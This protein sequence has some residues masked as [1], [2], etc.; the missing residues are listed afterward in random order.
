MRHPLVLIR[1]ANLVFEPL[2]NRNYISSIMITFKENVGVEGR[3]GYFD[4]FGN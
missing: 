3:G 2:W 4:E 1:F